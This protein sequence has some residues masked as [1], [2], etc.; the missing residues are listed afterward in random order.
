[1]YE[2]TIK[3]HILPSSLGDILN[4][5]MPFF[6]EYLE[7]ARWFGS[8]SMAIN[9]LS[10]Y[11]YALINSEMGLQ[12]VFY[13]L[14]LLNVKYESKEEIYFIPVVLAKSDT[15]T[16]NSQ[17]KILIGL[18]S[19]ASSERWL[20]IDGATEKQFCTL[21]L[22]AAVSH[23]KIPSERGEF[24]FNWES[25]DLSESVAMTSTSEKRDS[26]N[27]IDFIDSEQSNSSFILDK[28][29]ILKL[30]RKIEQGINP[31][32]EITIFLNATEFQNCPRL[33]A[34][35]DY[36]R[37]G[38]F[39]G[40][41]GIAEKYVINKGNCWDYYVNGANNLFGF[42]VEN[43]FSYN[44]GLSKKIL[45]DQFEDGIIAAYKIG[46]ITGKMHACLSSYTK[47]RDFNRDPISN[48][49]INTWKHVIR[50]NF[51]TFEK[52]V[53]NE[54][55]D[56]NFLGLAEP[57]PWIT[58]RQTLPSVLDKLNLLTQNNLSKIRIHGD[59]HLG[60]VLRTG[61]DFL[62][63]DF[64]GEPARPLNYRRNKFCAL[65]DV[66]GM[67]R[68]FSYSTYSPLIVNKVENARVCD[69]K[70]WAND[71][72][73]RLGKSFLEGY[74]QA[75]SAESSLYIVPSD[76]RSMIMCLVPFLLEKL[77][78]ELLYEINNRPMWLKIPAIGIEDLLEWE[79]SIS[80]N[81]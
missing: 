14:Q 63:I 40:N 47:D 39:F 1:M 70:K 9:D 24:V 66:A 75:V 55:F 53:K 12:A 28:R 65:K 78:Y 25:S 46:Q 13:I 67:L 31:E 44:A 61:N 72:N 5:L 41:V 6:R 30:I 49:D 69:M 4:E 11:D 16:R 57:Y 73:I 56:K 62:I 81:L 60:Q 37:G 45:L 36:T 32:K 77:V 68:S 54:T 22:T 2:V 29:I 59:Y 26:D 27:L 3:G 58:L 52:L 20:L 71:W 64:E 76:R 18:T 10:V 33:V 17:S 8:K 15:W 80:S 7:Q 38:N 43:S 48:V 42:V 79:Q 34:S 35:V 50:D 51:F 23:Q 74:W 21:L 19:G